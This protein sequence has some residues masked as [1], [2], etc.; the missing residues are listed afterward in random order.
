MGTSY[1]LSPGLDT[2]RVQL[3]YASE[4]NLSSNSSSDFS[5]PNPLLFIRPRVFSWDL[6]GEEKTFSS[7]LFLSFFFSFSFG[8]KSKGAGGRVE[9]RVERISKDRNR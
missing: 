7:F 9:E 4:S 6:V 1:T 2:K 3:L 5:S 8:G